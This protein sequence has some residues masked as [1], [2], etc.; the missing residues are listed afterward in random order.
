MEGA[1][2]AHVAHLN[3]VS[4]VIIPAISDDTSGE[5]DV[6]YEDF[7]KMEVENDSKMIEEMIQAANENL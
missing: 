4:F 7:V 5:A 6:K 1:A 3:E 2:I